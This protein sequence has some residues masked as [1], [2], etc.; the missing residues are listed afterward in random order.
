MMLERD[1]PSVAPERSDAGF[2]LIEM[3]IS[4]AL[5]AVLVSLLPGT[6]RL[7]DRVLRASEMDAA[8]QATMALLSAAEKSISATRPEFQVDAGGNVRADFVGLSD[9]VRVIASA[10]SGPGGGGVYEFEL[11]FEGAGGTGSQGLVLTQT[12]VHL[13]QGTAKRLSATAPAASRVRVA[14]GGLR[15]WGAAVVGEDP[16]WHDAWNDSRQFPEVIEIKV[17]PRGGGSQPIIS[18]I[19]LRMVAR[20][21]SS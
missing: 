8:H 17:V 2:S 12:L 3:I 4:L 5:L 13:L 21:S 1:I 9:R 18:T 14:G 16:A 15:Y 11:R 6:L 19:D 10:A 20:R 7:S